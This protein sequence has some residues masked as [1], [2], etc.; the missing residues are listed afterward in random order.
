MNKKMSKKLT[1]SSETLRNLNEPDLQQVAGQGTSA[2]MCS[3][4]VCS[5]TNI[6]SNCRPCL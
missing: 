1:L 4:A 5:A 2:G 3:P 6:C